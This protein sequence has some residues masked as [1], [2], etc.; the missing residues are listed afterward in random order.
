M[1][2]AHHVTKYLTISIQINIINTNMTRQR[3]YSGLQ[4]RKRRIQRSVP[5]APLLVSPYSLLFLLLILAY[6]FYFIRCTQLPLF[7]F[8]YYYPFLRD[9][10]RGPYD[11]SYSAF[12][13]Q[14]M[15]NILRESFALSRYLSNLGYHLGVTLSFNCIYC[16][17]IFGVAMIPPRWGIIKVT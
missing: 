7:I 13:M 10:L 2:R 3:V 12:I 4:K 9:K 17:T 1:T 6:Q 5:G 11:I 8:W 14:M 15:A 16:I